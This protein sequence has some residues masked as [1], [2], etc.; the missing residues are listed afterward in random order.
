MVAFTQHFDTRPDTLS[1]PCLD[2]RQLSVAFPSD[3]GL[4]QAVA[5]VSFQIQAGKTTALVGESG[6]GKSV[7]S[8]S[9]MRLLA[10]TANTQVQ[11]QAFYTNAQGVSQDLLRVP[12]AQMRSIRGNE[13]AMIFQEPMTSLNPVF[14]VGEQIAESLRWHKKLDRASALAQAL[15]MLELVEIPA[16]AQRIKEYPHQL[17]GGMRQ[18]VMIAI[19][20]A[21]S[22]R[23]LIADEPT[24][25]LDVTIQAQILALL[26]RLQTQT[27]MSMLFITHNLGVVAHHAHDVAV[28]YAGRIVE[29]APVQ[30]LFAQPQHHYTQGLLNC[31]PSRQRLQRGTGEDNIRNQRRLYAIRGQVSS[32]LAPPPGCAFAPRCDGA[33]AACE[34]AMPPLQHSSDRRSL[35]C[36]A[37]VVHAPSMALIK[38]SA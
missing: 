13:V 9:L 18:R 15:R 32:P 12:E 8:L 35:R 33:V 27:G 20:M 22:P 17:S 31:L 1:K 24:T 34:V 38:G 14:T 2:V 3:Q 37:P 7:T 19:A 29:S 25:A 23:L 6:S 16:A 5:E 28:M 10:K 4:V 30:N 21:C 26:G 36:I 11:G